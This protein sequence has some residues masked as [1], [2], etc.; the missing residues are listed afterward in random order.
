MKTY[1]EYFMKKLSPEDAA[2]AIKNTHVNLIDRPAQSFELAILQGFTWAES[3]Q[4]HEFWE[5]RAFK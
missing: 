3:P 5:K 4:G 1:R 2:E